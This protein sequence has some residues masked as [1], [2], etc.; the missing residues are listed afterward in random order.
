MIEVPLLHVLDPNSPS[1]YVK[2]PRKCQETYNFDIFLH[3]PK[4]TPLSLLNFGMNPNFDHISLCVYYYSYIIKSL[5]FLDCFVQKLSKKNL[6]G[7]ARPPS[8]FGKGRVNHPESKRQCL[9]R[10]IS[11]FKIVNIKQGE[12]TAICLRSR[13][14]C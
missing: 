6:W 9:N 1:I 7:S 10:A 14:K 3:F 4:F 2:C 8:P 12:T 5:M 13:G 11:H